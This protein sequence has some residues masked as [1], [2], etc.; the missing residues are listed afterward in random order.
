M[1]ELLKPLHRYIIS[2]KNASILGTSLSYD[3][4]DSFYEQHFAPV[5]LPEDLYLDEP[6][7][8]REVNPEEMEDVEEEDEDPDY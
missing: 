2:E 4:Y 7:E 8:I 5:T 3:D 6:T 1:A